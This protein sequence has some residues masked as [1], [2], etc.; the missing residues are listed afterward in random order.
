MPLALPAIAVGLG[1][2][3]TWLVL[4]GMHQGSNT[5][6][7]TLVE[8]YSK[9]RGGFIK[10]VATAPVRAI[11]RGVLRVEQVVR[12]AIAVALLATELAVV[13][14]LHGLADLAI[15]VGRELEDLGKGIEAGIERLTTVW[16][17]RFVHRALAPLERLAHEALRV[18]HRADAYAHAEASRLRHGIDRLRRDVAHDIARAR[19]GIEHGIA[20]RVLPRIR[21]LERTVEG[22]VTGALPRLRARER[23]LEREVYGRLTRRLSR[24]EKLIGAGLIGAVVIRTLAK[25]APWIFCRNVGRLGKTVCRLDAD[26]LSAI[27]AALLG[28]FAVADFETLIRYMQDA[29]EEIIEE[30]QRFLN[31][32]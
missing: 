24:L 27:E 26:T 15:G 11:A 5:W 2:I 17:P 31:V 20:A 13:S 29:E 8:E 10:R 32:A 23:A 7:R 28:A 30:I 14:W 12:A 16:I 6:L 21:G 22:A 19:R 25:V 9:P 1:L 4:Y 3:L 18:G